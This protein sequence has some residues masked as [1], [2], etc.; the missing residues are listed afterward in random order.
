M[1]DE[2]RIFWIRVKMAVNAAHMSWLETKLQ[3]VTLKVRIAEEKL[4]KMQQ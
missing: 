1:F 2:L 4:H 3:I